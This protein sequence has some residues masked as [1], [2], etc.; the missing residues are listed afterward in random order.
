[1]IGPH[2][3]VEP[4]NR[5][6]SIVDRW[7]GFQTF[8]DQSINQSNPLD[9]VARWKDLAGHDSQLVRSPGL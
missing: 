2:I 9:Q 1:M 7:H 8:F 5:F 4:A 3:H 6:P